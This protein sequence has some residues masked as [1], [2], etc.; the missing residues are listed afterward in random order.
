MLHCGLH[1]Y[2]VRKLKAEDI[3]WPG[4]KLRIEQSKGLKDRFVFLSPQAAEALQ[5]YLAV[6]GPSETPNRLE[7]YIDY[8]FT[9]RHRPLGSVYCR[10]RIRT[11]AIA[12]RRCCSTPVPR[13]WRCRHP[14]SPAD[15]HH[16]EHLVN[17]ALSK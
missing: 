5:A 8:V 7:K 1:A 6:R 4:R 12:V 14:R 15:R 11:Y 16:I 9:Y 2:E 10:N 3:D 13:S 17:G